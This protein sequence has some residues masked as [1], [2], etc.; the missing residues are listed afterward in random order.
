MAFSAVAK[1][2]VGD[3]RGL[4]RYLLE[5][6]LDHMNM[7]N[8]LQVRGYQS[9]VFPIQ[10][11]EDA[12]AWLAAHQRMSQSV[13]TQLGAAFRWIT[14]IGTTFPFTTAEGG[15]FVWDAGTAADGAQSIDLEHVDWENESDVNNWQL[16]HANWHRQ[17]NGALGL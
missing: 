2:R 13:W 16:I 1:W 6:Y 14:S 4:Q 10:R 9:T 15:I 17:V 11:M 12:R 5:H 7:A 3:E 8:C